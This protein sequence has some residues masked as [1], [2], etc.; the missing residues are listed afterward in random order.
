MFPL[1]L[2][3]LISSFCDNY[4][5]FKLIQLNTSFYKTFHPLLK[6]NLTIYLHS[7]TQ[8]P[9]Y[10]LSQLSY[11][12]SKLLFNLIKFIPYC[13]D[14]NHI[15]FTNTFMNKQSFKLYINPFY[16]NVIL[17]CDFNSSLFNT[18]FSNSIVHHHNF[19]NPISFIEHCFPISEHTS[20]INR[21]NTDFSI[22]FY[23]IFGD[24]SILP[25]S[26]SRVSPIM[27]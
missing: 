12:E 16:I 14:I 25:T 3:Y 11:L 10:F 26:R 24:H 4:T 5:I 20:T 22:L 17:S 13:S 15:R 19:K 18:V 21:N 23:Y 27:H 8:C 6:K 9:V 2:F 1:E 7:K